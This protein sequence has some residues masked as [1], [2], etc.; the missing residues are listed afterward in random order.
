MP[1]SKA[2]CPDSSVHPF[3]TLKDC[4]GLQ[5]PSPRIVAVCK[6][7][8]LFS[9]DSENNSGKLPQGHGIKKHQLPIKY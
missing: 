1:C 6:D 2:L 3:V 4:E 9:D 5:K 8:V 7:R